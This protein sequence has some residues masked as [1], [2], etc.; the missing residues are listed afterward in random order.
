MAYISGQGIPTNQT[1]AAIGDIYTDT[2]T[3]QKYKCDLAYASKDEKGNDFTYYIWIKLKNESSGSGGTTDYTN[4]TNKPQI[5][6]VD[7]VGNKTSDDLS[8]IDGTAFDKLK[9]DIDVYRNT[10][11]P[12]Y[13]EENGYIYKSGVVI[14]NKDWK[15]SSPIKVM[16][17]S[18]IIYTGRGYLSDV[19]MI[20]LTDKNGSNYTPAIISEGNNFQNYIYHAN[21]DCYI[22][23]SYSISDISRM[24]LQ[25]SDY[26]RDILLENES[27]IRELQEKVIYKTYENKIDF[28]NVNNG[29]Y[30]H[31]NGLVNAIGS[32]S[33]TKPF[34]CKKGTKVIASCHGYQNNVAIISKVE[35]SK[36]IPLV[37]SIDNERHNY[38]YTFKENSMCVVC[39]QNDRPYS[40]YTSYTID[41][42]MLSDT[43]KKMLKLQNTISVRVRYMGL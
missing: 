7:L 38:E 22:A 36:Y 32:Y 16:R 26:D 9:E 18:I 3:Q 2:D 41:L 27:K 15:H 5:N 25:I 29:Y 14:E 10:F 42:D 35:D 21:S 24:K 4:L 23:I 13:I 1:A 6:S 37:I 19:T 39:Y 43:V 28:S 40:G 8:L 17:G 31:N 30:I 34:F 12:E 20:A 11:T 33:I